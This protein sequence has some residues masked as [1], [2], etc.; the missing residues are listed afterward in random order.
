M[1]VY[2]KTRSNAQPDVKVIDEYSVWVASDIQQISEP[3]TTEE[4]SGFEGYEY[5]LTQY[6]KD[7]YIRLIDDRAAELE[8]ALTD[9]ETALTELYE[10]IM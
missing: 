2:P 3:G 4:D 1:K 10:S 9:T 7:E 8:E 5:T 6:D